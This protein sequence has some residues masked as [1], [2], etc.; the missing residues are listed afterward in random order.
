MPVRR[1]TDSTNDAW[2][3]DF[4]V[5]GTRHRITVRA[6]NK[7]AAQALERQ[8]RQR[9]EAGLRRQRD[10]PTVGDSFARYW[11]EHGRLLASA[12]TERGYLNRW[13]DAL[14]E[15]TPLTSVT[16]ARVSAIVALWRSAPGVALDRHRQPKDRQ[17][18]ADSTLNH[19]L[20]CL[21][22]IWARAEDVWGWR[23]PRIPWRRLK[24]YEPS[25]LPDRSI[26]RATLRAL[27]RAIAPRSR[28]LVMMAYVTGLRRGA[29]LR[30]QTTDVDLAGG[31]VRAV[32]KGRAGGKLTPVPITR[33]V[34]WVLRRNGAREVGRLF[35]VTKQEIRSDWAAARAELGRPDLVLKDLRHSFA[36]RLEDAGA[37]DLISDALHHSDP[38]LRRRYAKA[39]IDRMRERLDS[40]GTATGTARRNGRKSAR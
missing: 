24:L 25:E 37:G 30:L 10:G 20:L 17:R 27:L 32:S 16:A 3:L 38:R 14:G 1:R 35:E 11:H 5:A 19:R 4:R 29:L 6:P 7:R 8:E 28:P 15:D 2:L 13:A 39:K 36:Q 22:R 33:R 9:I 31:V 12:P 18:V 21:Q 40:L 23:L 26:A 34:R